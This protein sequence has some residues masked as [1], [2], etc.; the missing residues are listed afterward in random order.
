MLITRNLTFKKFCSGETPGEVCSVTVSRGLYHLKGSSLH[1][2]HL[3]ETE[4]WSR[5]QEGSEEDLIMG[6]CIVPFTMMHL[7]L[8]QVP[9]PTLYHQSQMHSPGMNLIRKQVTYLPSFKGGPPLVV[10]DWRKFL[11]MER[12][13]TL[14]LTT[15]CSY[16]HKNSFVRHLLTDSSEKEKTADADVKHAVTSR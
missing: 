8:F 9:S 15:Q 10:G 16:T 4:V 14:C 13:W 11:I 5:K 6:I 7:M 2:S 3:P 12:C 1:S